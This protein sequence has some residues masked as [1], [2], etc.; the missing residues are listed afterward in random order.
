MITI[1]GICVPDDD[2]LLIEQLRSDPNYADR[3][4]SYV[5]VNIAVLPTRRIALDIGANVGLWSRRLVA[6]FDHVHAFEPLA[7]A[8]DCFLN[9]VRGSYTLHDCAIGEA[10]RVVA[11]YSKPTSMGYRTTQKTHVVFIDS[12]QNVPGTVRMRTV[13]SFNFT[14][15]DFIKVDCEGFDYYALQGALKT[16]HAWRPDIMF[17]AKPMV[18]FKRYGLKDWAPAKLMEKMG[19]NILPIGHGNFYCTHKA[20][21]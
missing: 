2:E 14:N 1:N 10:E 3:Y 9:N 7:A 18:S 13:D 6:L 12:L 17:E 16:I 21:K 20:G 15:V 4:D 5:M 8:R 19:Y 11:L